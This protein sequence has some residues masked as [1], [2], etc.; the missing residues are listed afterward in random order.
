[1]KR[2]TKVN[3]H[4][5]YGADPTQYRQ[6]KAKGCLYGYHH[7]E[8]ENYHLTYSHDA[9]EGKIRRFFRKGLKAAVGFDFLHTWHNRRQILDADVVWTHTEFEYLAVALL[10]RLHRRPKNPLLLAQSVWLF[11]RWHRYGPVRRLLYRSL[12]KRADMM[13]THSSI[14]QKLCK[15]CLGL[16]ATQVFYG[17]CT[18]DF[19]IST[20]APWRPHSPLRIAAIG[21]D[22]D[23][24]WDTLI[25]SFYDDNRFEVRLATRRRVR[26]AKQ[27]PN[28]K[29]GPVFGL[30]AQRELYYW[31]DVIV[32]PLRENKHV[33]GITVI[34]ESVT[35]GKPVIAT[36]VGG[37]QEYFSP[38]E[39]T[40]VPVADAIALRDAALS[41]SQSPEDAWNKALL[42]SQRLITSGYTTANFA[43]QHVALTEQMLAAACSPETGEMLTEGLRGS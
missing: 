36:D 9:K 20:V 22:R 3:V 21:N 14:N 35:Y 39:V 18:D 19:P 27:S 4:L 11:D 25:D 31:A 5:F 42:A 10:L 40:Y 38:N 33:S 28:I 41:L 16:P 32:V 13:T 37:L 34:L 1:M 24:D 12:A 8:S 15:T 26:S 30:A 6:G 7:A 29:I 23:R 17:I 2:P 43:K